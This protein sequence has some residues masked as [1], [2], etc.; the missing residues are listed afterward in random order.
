MAKVSLAL[1]KVTRETSV[2][3]ELATIQDVQQRVKDG[4]FFSASGIVPG[5]LD[6]ATVEIL[7]RAVGNSH[8]RPRIFVGGDAT[9]EL[10]EGPTVIADGTP[11]ISR[12]RN[13]SESLKLAKSSVFSTPTIGAL[14]THLESAFIPGGEKKDSIG[15]TSEFLPWILS[16]Q[17]YLFRITNNAQ[18][19]ETI[20]VTLDWFEI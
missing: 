19:A 6:G 4:V 2:G 11:V 8:M 9:I 12:N 20:S 7:F 16:E 5:V 18:Q 3:D 14:G 15:G 13:R 10:C 1:Q 17:D